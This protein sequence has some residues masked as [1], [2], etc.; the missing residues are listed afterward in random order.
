M[1]IPMTHRSK[2][3]RRATVKKPRSR[4]FSNEQRGHA[5]ASFGF[6]KLSKG[7]L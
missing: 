7:G 2:H 4:T 3:S 5:D 1:L 6:M